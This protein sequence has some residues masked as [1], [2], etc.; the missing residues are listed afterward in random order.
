MDRSFA[1]LFVLVS[2]LAT[3]AVMVL[4]GALRGDSALLT[5][6]GVALVLLALAGVLVL[7]R[8]VVLTERRRGRL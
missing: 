1:R 3:A 8:V 6:A 5:V 2:I 4:P 7:A